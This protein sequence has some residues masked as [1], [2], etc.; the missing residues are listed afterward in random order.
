MSK[1]V[2][3]LLYD[4]DVNKGGITSVILSRSAELSNRYG[5]DVDLVSLDYKSNYDE[6][7]AKLTK[8]GRLSTKVNILN[9][10]NYYRDKNCSGYMKDE[11]REYFKAVSFL[12]EKGYYVQVNEYEKK[13]FA[14]YFQN[15]QY[16]KYKK[17]SKDGY[18]THID[19][20]DQN[21]NRMYREE[22]H[23]GGYIYRKI[24]FDLMSNQPKEEQ[25]FTKDGFCFLSKWLNHKNGNIQ[26]IFLFNRITKQVNEFKNNKEFH[27]YW[28][29]ELCREQNEKPYLIC[30]GVGSAS[31][32]LSIDPKVAYRI[33]TIHTNHFDAPHEF[34]SPIK[35]D[36][37]TLLNNLKNEEAL[38]VL[39]ESQKKDIVKQF[40]DYKNVYVIPNFITPITN[41]KLNR[42]PRLVT[43]IA[44]YHPEKGID[45]A[46]KAFQKVVKEVPDAI[47]EIYGHGEDEDRLRRIINELN[48]GKSVF[49]KGYTTKI[50]EVL[51]RTNVTIL[52]SQFEG[53]NV[54]SL[55][56]MACHIPVISYNVKYGMSDI[57]K[58]GETGY[59]VPIG[60]QAALASRIID[61]LKNPKKVKTMGKAAHDYVLSKF[62]KEKVCQQWISLFDQ[63]ENNN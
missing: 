56:S 42:V 22:F 53:L 62:S 4:I 18:L 55:E 16:I 14:R 59:L 40:G 48:L 32:V 51:G 34:G 19:Y 43:M 21:R 37:V 2:F 36:H 45:E 10:H 23:K 63:L 57:I 29:N 30:D 24:Y 9:V 20:F 35:K 46:I 58:N 39:T 33:Y 15:G 54:V 1:R 28:L 11:Q 60:D 49:L 41:Y 12:E 31:K 8:D 26:K 5:Y 38:V 3:M 7:R 50:G 17:W 52:T 6:I 25:H 13:H 61:I 47:F 27:V 44:R